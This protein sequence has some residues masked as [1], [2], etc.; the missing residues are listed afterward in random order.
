MF[1]GGLNWDTN[2]ETLQG[3]FAQFGKVVSCNIMRD[4]LGRSRGFAFLTFEDAASVNAVM[5]KEHIVDGK[6]VSNMNDLR[7]IVSTA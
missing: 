4:Q 5:A 1:V 2:D 3:Y 6:V 7:C